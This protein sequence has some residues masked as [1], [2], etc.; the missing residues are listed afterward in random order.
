MPKN[1][2]HRRLTDTRAVSGLSFD[3]SQLARSSRVRALAAGLQLA[4]ECRD[5][6]LHH[7]A[8]SRPSS[9]RAPACGSP[10]AW[11]PPPPPRAGS[12]S[13]ASASACS[14]RAASFTSGCASGDAHS[15]WS[16][17]ACLL[18]VACASPPPPSSAFSTASGIS[19]PLSAMRPRVFARRKRQPEAAHGGA[20]QVGILVDAS[21]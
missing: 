9:C 13:P 21:P 16:A 5:R 17:I 3:T 4:Q 10:S 11:S 18:R 6:R 19:F 15:K 20:P 7:L 2:R 8:R 14:S 1:C 12:P